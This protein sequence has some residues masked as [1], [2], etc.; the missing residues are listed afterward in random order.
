MMAYEVK[1]AVF[2]GPLDLLLQLIT[3][4]QLDVADVNLSSRRH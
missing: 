1:T 2:E 3:R 4:S